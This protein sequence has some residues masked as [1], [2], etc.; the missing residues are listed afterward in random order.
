[1]LSQSQAR[2]LQELQEMLALIRWRILA[3]HQHI[4]LGAKQKMP[5]EQKLEPEA[6]KKKR[7]FNFRVP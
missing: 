4:H 2:S 6:K 1:M 3:A 5:F 7:K